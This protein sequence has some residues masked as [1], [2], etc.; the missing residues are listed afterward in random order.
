[1]TR[2]EALRHQRQAL[3][4][5]LERANVHLLRALDELRP[6]QPYDKLTSTVITSTETNAQ[7]CREMARIIETEL[8]DETPRLPL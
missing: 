8:S 5:A 4:A 1:M 2:D 7:L 3:R 6:V